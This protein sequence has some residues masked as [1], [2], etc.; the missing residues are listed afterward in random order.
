MS[1]FFGG[2]LTLVRRHSMRQAMRSERWQHLLAAAHSRRQGHKVGRQSM[3]SRQVLVH[4]S[5]AGT[6]GSRAVVGAHR[7][8]RAADKTRILELDDDLHPVDDHNADTMRQP[9]RSQFKNPYKSLSTANQQR[10]E[11]SHGLREPCYEEI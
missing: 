6:L 11:D 10:F 3:G 4:A 5:Q 2:G 1:F 9:M 8:D 7:I